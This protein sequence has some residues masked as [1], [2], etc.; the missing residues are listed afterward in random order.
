MRISEFDYELPKELI[1]Q[2][3]PEKR[4]SSRM[5]IVNRAKEIRSRTNIFAGFHNF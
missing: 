1:A 3:P 5:L 4:E 2:T